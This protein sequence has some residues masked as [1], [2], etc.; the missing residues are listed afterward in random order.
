MENSSKEVNAFSQD[1]LDKISIE[2]NIK[3][4]NPEK[5]LIYFLKEMNFKLNSNEVKYPKVIIIFI[6]IIIYSII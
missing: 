5:D 3:T 1:N 6:I 2:L 4:L